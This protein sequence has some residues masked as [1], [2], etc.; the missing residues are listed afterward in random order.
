MMRNEARVAPSHADFQ[1]F[2]NLTPP[3]VIHDDE[4]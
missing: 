3:S 1:R 2:F 4:R